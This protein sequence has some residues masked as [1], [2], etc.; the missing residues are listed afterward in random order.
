MYW[1][2]Q[3]ISNLNW[4]MEDRIQTGHSKNKV[5]PYKWPKINGFDWGSCSLL[6][7]CVTPCM[8]G[9]LGPPCSYAIYSPL[10]KT[11]VIAKYHVSAGRTANMVYLE[12][13]NLPYKYKTLGFQTPKVKRYLDPK[14]ITSKHRSQEV[15]IIFFSIHD[16]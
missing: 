4:D 16:M 14:N 1:G 13:D 11:F 5:G 12:T 3:M 8:T 15:H 9:F 7:G 6:V 10:L 2:V